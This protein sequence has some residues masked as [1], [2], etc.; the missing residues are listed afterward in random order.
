MAHR[1]VG[2]RVIESLGLRVRIIWRSHADGRP[3]G[4]LVAPVACFKDCMGAK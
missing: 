1:S 4:A 2:F 3:V